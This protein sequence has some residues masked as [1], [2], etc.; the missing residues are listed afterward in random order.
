MRRKESINSKRILA[1]HS[2]VFKQ[3]KLLVRWRHLKVPPLT[4]SHRFATKIS[5]VAALGA[6]EQGIIHIQ[7]V[8]MGK[9]ALLMLFTKSVRAE[10][11]VKL[12]GFSSVFPCWAMVPSAQRPGRDSL[13]PVTDGSERDL[14]HLTPGSTPGPADML[15]MRNW[16]LKIFLQ[17]YFFLQNPLVSPKVVAVFCGVLPSLRVSA[18]RDGS[19]KRVCEGLPWTW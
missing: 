5:S 14:D 13:P 3:R 2:L 12:F 15:L 9:S 11:K 1:T 17:A 4:F 16:N 10:V 18:N 6:N 7:V 8:L 19:P